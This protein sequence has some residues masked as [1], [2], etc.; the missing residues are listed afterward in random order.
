MIADHEGESLD[1]I[2]TYQ[3]S[4]PLSSLAF[5]LS[6][7]YDFEDLE[8]ASLSSRLRVYRN[9][10]DFGEG[11]IDLEATLD[12]SGRVEYRFYAFDAET[13]STLG[14]DAETVATLRAFADESG[15]QTVSTNAHENILK[16]IFQALAESLTTKEHAPLRANSDAEERA[17]IDAFLASETIRV[18]SG[19]TTGDS[20][21]VDFRFD[22]DAFIVFLD[23]VADILGD[24]HADK[25]FASDSGLFR[26]FSL[27]GE[28]TIDDNDTLD[29]ANFFIEIPLS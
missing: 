24:E 18:F 28:M 9:R 15:G 2:G 11:D 4:E 6:G 22:P 17:I 25:T 27:A 5:T 13:L 3:L 12:S 19:A 16:E 1:R 10:R 29:R 23:R 20:D 21:R 7:D 26:A 14:I 8:N